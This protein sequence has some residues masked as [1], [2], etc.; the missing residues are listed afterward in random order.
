MPLSASHK[1]NLTQRSLRSGV[2]LLNGGAGGRNPQIRV[3]PPLGK[4][5]LINMYHFPLR[6]L[7]QLTHHYVELRL[8]VA[9][10]EIVSIESLE[11]Y[12]SRWVQIFIK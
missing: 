6:L 11:T 10:I 5:K 1:S 4:S 3:L 9:A 2:P 8:T 12:F 7:Q